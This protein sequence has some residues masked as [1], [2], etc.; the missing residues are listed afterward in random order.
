VQGPDQFWPTHAR[1]VPAFPVNT[2]SSDDGARMGMT[3]QTTRCHEPE[4]IN[5]NMQFPFKCCT[6]KVLLKSGRAGCLAMDTC[7]SIKT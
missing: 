5:K 7:H 4:D 1:W 2:F 6:E 3:Y